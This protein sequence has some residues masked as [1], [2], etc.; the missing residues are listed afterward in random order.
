MKAVLNVRGVDV[1]LEGDTSE[2]VRLINSVSEAPK[3]APVAAQKVPKGTVSKRSRRHSLPWNET[4]LMT[5]VE[6]VQGH[7]LDTRGLPE[8]GVKTLRSKLS[9]SDSGIHNLTWRVQQYLQNNP[10]GKRHLSKRIMKALDKNDVRPVA[11]EAVQEEGG[12]L[13]RV[14][15]QGFG[16]VPVQEA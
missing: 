5:V 3:A 8:K 4:E 1:Q 13:G 10:E 9:R 6:F 12:F 15:A 14:N 11:E 2:I 16:R 7:K